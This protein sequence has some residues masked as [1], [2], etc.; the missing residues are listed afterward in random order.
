MIGDHL[1]ETAALANFIYSTHYNDLDTNTVNMAK[2]CILDWIGTALSGS[3]EHSS[4][5]LSST[6]LQ[7]D[8]LTTSSNCK[9]TIL[10]KSLGCA[11]P[12][13]AAAVNAAYSHSQDF[14]DLHN[15]STV[16]P[17]V[18]TIPTALALGQHLNL[19]G[20]EIITA[21]VIGYDVATRIGEAINPSAYYFWHTTSVVGPLSSAAVA[22]KI[23]NLSPLQIAN[24]LG[25]AGTQAGGLWAFLAEGAM[26]KLLHVANANICGIRSAELAR[27]GFTASS[28]ILENPRGFINALSPQPHLDRILLDLGRNFKINSTS[29]KPYACCRHTHSA[30]FGVYSMKAKYQFDIN[31]IAKIEDFTYRTAMTIANNSHPNNPY[32]AKFSLQ[33]CI[34]AALLFSNLNEQA[35]CQENLENAQIEKLMK[36]IHV[37]FSEDIEENYQI[38]TNRW[39]HKLRFTMTDG[40]IYEELFDYPF[41]DFKNP[42][43]WSDVNNKFQS[44]SSSIIGEKRTNALISRIS[45][46]DQLKSTKNLFQIL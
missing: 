24:A 34:A 26:S 33:Y 35:F 28:N 12:L 44:L 31:K 41:G 40:L 16:H 36:K 27:N 22:S 32:A 30:C 6:L 43:T 14:D 1:V 20:K 42:F 37:I 9:S 25:S 21:I 11:P 23:F 38:D 4:S 10:D 17:A 46:F 7:K 18:I 39:G 45:A 19:S 8:Y 3:Q 15:S 13:L 29:F 5:I 2:M